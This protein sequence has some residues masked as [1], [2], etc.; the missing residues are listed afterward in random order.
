M[1]DGR[2]PIIRRI[3][4]SR[5][6]ARADRAARLAWRLDGDFTAR[7]V[8]PPDLVSMETTTPIGVPA[9]RAEEFVDGRDGD[10]SRESLSIRRI[11]SLRQRRGH[12]HD[13][14]VV[15]FSD[16]MNRRVGR[17]VPPLLPLVL[18]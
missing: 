17:R 14:V 15:W 16:D 8:I 11:A 1:A 13:E 7:H 18:V 3:P 6:R 4:I 9:L 5:R 10:G 2:W 12:L